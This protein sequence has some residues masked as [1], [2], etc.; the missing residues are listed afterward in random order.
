M[1]LL[2]KAGRFKCVVKP[3]GESWIGESTGKGTLYIGLPLEVT[4][5]E[6]A[7]KHIT[8]SLYLSEAA[9]DNTIE[10]MAEV[11]GWD[12][13]LDAL[14]N[15]QFSFEGM[16]CSIET[17]MEDWTNA[18]GVTSKRCKV[19]WVNR[20]GGG[21]FVKAASEDKIKN[22]MAKNARSKALAAE[23]LKSAGVAPT[24]NKPEPVAMGINEKEPLPF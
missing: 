2:N 6:E 8:A 21:S 4:E 17:E 1:P 7:G 20:V 23:K 15:G 16:E 22:L 13:D 5:G 14:M 9:F 12:G 19:A 18:E 24:K 11:F 10:R 3:C